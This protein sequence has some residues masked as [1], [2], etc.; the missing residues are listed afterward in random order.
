MKQIFPKLQ[1]FHIETIMYLI[2]IIIALVILY[3]FMNNKINLFE[4]FQETSGTSTQTKQTCIPIPTQASCAVDTNPST[5]FN[6]IYY[7]DESDTSKTFKTKIW[8]KIFVPVDGKIIVDFRNAIT[9][10]ANTTLTALKA[11]GTTID[12]WE[13]Y[14]YLEIKETMEEFISDNTQYDYEYEYEKNKILKQFVEDHY[15]EI[16]CHKPEQ[17][18]MCRRPQTYTLSGDIAPVVT[19]AS[20]E[21]VLAEIYAENPNIKY[22]HRGY[23]YIHPYFERHFND[24]FIIKHINNEYHV[25]FI[26]RISNTKTIINRFELSGYYE[27]A[28]DKPTFLNS[29]NTQN[30]SLK[31]VGN[32]MHNDNKTTSMIEKYVTNIIKGKLGISNCGP[33]IIIENTEGTSTEA[34]DPSSKIFTDSIMETGGT[35]DIDENSVANTILDSSP[36]ET[37]FYKDIHSTLYPSATDTTW[38]TIKCNTVPNHTFKIDI[39]YKNNCKMSHDFLTYIIDEYATFK[40]LFPTTYTLSTDTLTFFN[41]SDDC[42]DSADMYCDT[43]DDNDDNITKDAINNIGTISKDTSFPDD[44]HSKLINEDGNHNLKLPY[45][46]MTLNTGDPYKKSFIWGDS[47]SKDNFE[48]IIRQFIEMLHQRGLPRPTTATG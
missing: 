25:E 4:G 24:I 11:Y 19:E 31:I 13:Q 6:L 29:M 27:P 2:V 14:I 41:V 8:D 32:K 45:I 37:T 3:L 43:N 47:I 48:A 12:D 34:S 35:H 44:F 9:K 23:Y 5:T 33:A 17:K 42:A 36:L 39:Y 40:T 38:D 26:K 28:T 10:S 21:S 30:S 18:L 7:H 16:Y 20:G 22:V 15:S 1:R 46:V